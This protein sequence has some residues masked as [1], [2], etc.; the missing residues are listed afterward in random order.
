MENIQTKYNNKI[1]IFENSIIYF[2]NKFNNFDI[3]KLIVNVEKNIDFEMKFA[4][5]FDKVNW[6]NPVDKNDWEFEY[7]NI[8]DLNDYYI[9]IWCRKTNL[10]TFEAK[11]LYLPF[12]VNDVNTNE[13]IISD[14]S[15]DGTKI[16]FCENTIFIDT[17][18]KIISTVAKWNF[19]DNQQ[20]NIRRWLDNCIS[21][22]NMYGHQ[23][24]Y[25]KTEATETNHTFANNVLRNV[26]AIKKIPIISPDNELPQDRNVYTEWDMPMEGEFVI[27]VVDEI[28][29]LAFGENKVPLSKDYLYL[30]IINK[31]F[32]VSS[33]QPVNGFMGKIGW[34]KFSYQNMKMMKQ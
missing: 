5:S 2:K 15:Y 1:N 24:I 3:D 10:D 18:N 17:L 29:K 25:F 8:D 14:I 9:S 19:Y 20:V 32:R 11:S 16:E 27:H 23:C 26:V 33:V 21:I 34:W 31:L 12:N 22:V 13:L 4:Y 30:P 6:S 7:N 28:F